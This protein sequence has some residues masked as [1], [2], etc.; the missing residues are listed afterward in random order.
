MCWCLFWRSNYSF[1]EFFFL[2]FSD[3]TNFFM[4]FY[5]WTLKTLFLLLLFQRSAFLIPP[6]RPVWRLHVSMLHNKLC[7]RKRQQ[8][9]ERIFRF[10][11]LL[12]R[13]SAWKW[14]LMHLC[15]ANFGRNFRFRFLFS[16]WHENLWSPASASHNLL[17]SNFVSFHWNWLTV[18]DWTL[19]AK[20]LP[21]SPLRLPP[22]RR[23][24]IW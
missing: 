14:E 18:S 20:L 24:E 9:K 19:F 7:C 23:E 10:S 4:C 12:I 6:S 21:T 3:K 13:E 1:Q 8:R 5:F 11:L 17:H 22:P 2:S 16:F 15:E